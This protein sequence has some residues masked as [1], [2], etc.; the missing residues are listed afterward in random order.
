[1]DMVDER[2]YRSD[3]PAKKGQLLQYRYVATGAGK[4]NEVGVDGTP[5]H[6]R[7]FYITNH[8]QILDSIL[9]FSVPSSEI[10]S[11]SIQGTVR[12]KDSG[13]PA[14]G[15]L[16]TAAGIT[17]STSIE[18]VFRLEGIPAGTQNVTIFSPDGSVEPLQQQAVI[19]AN[20]IT[21]IDVE[22]VSRKMVNVTFIVS[23]PGSTPPLATLRV[24]G[25]VSQMGDS[26]AGLFG[27][28]NMVQNRAPVLA[29]RSNNKYFA[30]IQVP[31]N[32]Q[33]QYT[34]SLGD[35]FWNRET[36]SNG[37][38]LKRSIFISQ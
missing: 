10:I 19:E 15:I 4:L 23:T 16:V 25:N 6:S 27:G 24:F 36:N 9:G 13:K 21:P 29:R 3:I 32:T 18:G 1:M 20:S 12:L 28:T 17:C 35:A 38:Y 5:L 26:F 31:E 30:V 7:F 33:I 22:L 34:Y 8:T 11:G 2:H 37:E 14:T